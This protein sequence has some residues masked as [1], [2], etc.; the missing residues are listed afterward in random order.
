MLE[1]YG[2]DGSVLK[3]DHSNDVQVIEGTNEFSLSADIV[4]NVQPTKAY[5]ETSGGKIVIDPAK[6]TIYSLK[7][8]AIGNS[9][10]EYAM[11]WLCGIADNLGV[12]NIILGNMY[13]AF[14]KTKD[15]EIYTSFHVQTN[16][17][18]PGADRRAVIGKVKFGVD[19][20]G[21]IT[22]KIIGCIN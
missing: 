4:A 13:N 7:V 2:D 18:N 3:T 8:L 10:S 14:F 15:G 22:E 17:E 19:E 1:T 21:E 11:R 16:P 20:T 12:D 5:I 9:F 6:K